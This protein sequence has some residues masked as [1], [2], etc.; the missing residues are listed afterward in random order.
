MLSKN[1]YSCFG[2]YPEKGAKHSLIRLS[3]LLPVQIIERLLHRLAETLSEFSWIEGKELAVERTN[4][5]LHVFLIA[6]WNTQKTRHLVN[7]EAAPEPRDEEQ[8]SN[9]KQ[10]GNRFFHK[11][12][13]CSKGLNDWRK[14]E[15]E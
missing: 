5:G 12:L 1:P 3:F 2:E 13:P 4:T 10:K 7:Y 9:F 15:D 11:A 8:E 14:S 6:V